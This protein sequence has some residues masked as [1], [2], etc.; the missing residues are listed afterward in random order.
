MSQSN[1]VFTN[2]VSE[3]MESIKAKFGYLTMVANE[4]TAIE[5]KLH[6]KQVAKVEG[7]TFFVDELHLLY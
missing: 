5:K 1:M 2:S 6:E 3:A 7:V 4:F